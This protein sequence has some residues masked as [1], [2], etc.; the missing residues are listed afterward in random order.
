MPCFKTLILKKKQ[1]ITQEALINYTSHLQ[2][3]II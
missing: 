2:D 1:R 3:S